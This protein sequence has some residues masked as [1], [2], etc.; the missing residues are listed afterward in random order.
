MINI[1]SKEARRIIKHLSINATDF[2][3]DLMP[4]KIQSIATTDK[5][6]R[7]NYPD[8]IGIVVK[9]IPL[10]ERIKE[11]IAFMDGLNEHYPELAATRNMI[12]FEGER[13]TGD[14]LV[15][16]IGEYLLKMGFE[17]IW[18]DNWLHL[19][20]KKDFHD[21]IDQVDVSF[22][23][24][25]VPRY[26]GRRIRNRRMNIQTLFMDPEHHDHQIFMALRDVP[27]T[28][29]WEAGE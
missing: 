5:S 11:F 6:A 7:S 17:Q 15:R 1:E 9:V 4:Y 28:T 27:L 14:M 2:N 8:S 10:E 12:E 24:E 22:M 20:H 29:V 25:T 23:K 3:N 18:I 26:L 16:N 21:D 13:V 19:I